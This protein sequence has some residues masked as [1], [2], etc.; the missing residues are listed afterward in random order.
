MEELCARASSVEYWDGNA[1]WYK[2]WAEHNRYHDCI[3]RILTCL[4]KPGWKVL[5]VGA[6]HGV[7]SL[8][9]GAMGCKVTALEPSRGM[10]VFLERQMMERGITSIVVESARWEDIPVSAIHD[11][12]LIVASNSLHLTE[13]GFL[14]ALKKVFLAKPR[15]AFVVAEKQFLKDYPEIDENG[16]VRCF[17]IHHA[18]ESSYVYHTHE[19]AL[20]HWSFKHE[21]QPDGSEKVAIISGL[22]YDRGHFRQWGSAMVCMFWWVRNDAYQYSKITQA[23]EVSN[24]YHQDFTLPYFLRDVSSI[25]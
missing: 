17:K 2:L 16:Y 4:V 20:E 8:P 10:R 12:D 9:L 18:V 6:G 1:K 13:T 7:L 21:R 24:A 23:K 11:Y 25:R 15:H 14:Q 22:A 3:I 5:D 19:E